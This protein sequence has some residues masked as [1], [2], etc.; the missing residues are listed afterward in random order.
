MNDIKNITVTTK[1]LAEIFQVSE[2]Y[3][4]DLVN[5][6]QMPKLGFNKFPLVDCIKFRIQHL[7]K[8]YDDKLIKQRDLTN[9]GRLEAAQAE[10]KE[11]ELKKMQGELAP[12]AEFEL[13]QKNEALLFS[14][15]VNGFI[16]ELK[17]DLNLTPEQS[18][19]MQNKAYNLLN[20]Y[21]SL[22]PETNA[23]SFIYK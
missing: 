22:P 14:K 2:S 11:L 13:A 9:R 7:Q 8:I 12:V 20:R 19:Q 10:I 23:E 15:L 5:D 21:S 17:F 16:S 3:I 4:S 6:H 18:E 1:Q